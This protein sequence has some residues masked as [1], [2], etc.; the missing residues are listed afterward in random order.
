M[1]SNYRVL[2]GLWIEVSRYGVLVTFL[3]LLELGCVQA[4]TL[5]ECPGADGV[6]LFQQMQCASAGGS[7]LQVE[8]HTS[9]W[10]VVK[11]PK[12]AKAAK[13]RR[14]KPRRVSQKK[15]VSEVSCWRAEKRKE[16]AGRKLRRGYKPSEG[17]RLRHKRRDAEEYLRRFC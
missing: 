6:P 3:W 16:K 17:E 8:T 9:P 7:E 10:R 14:R 13:K 15:Q 11:V 1:M 5:Y 4:V 12:N 2:G